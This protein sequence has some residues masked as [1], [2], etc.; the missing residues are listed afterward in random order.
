M[1]KNTT[2]STSSEVVENVEESNVEEGEQED[3][4]S[5]DARHGSV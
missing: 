1:D 5:M 3:N 2:D 4:A